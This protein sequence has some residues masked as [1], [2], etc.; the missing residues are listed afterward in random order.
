MRRHII[1]FDFKIFCSRAEKKLESIN[2]H[3]VCDCHHVS[4]VQPCYPAAARLL[5][6]L[7]LLSSAG[8]A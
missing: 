5:P 6:I 4:R 1:E 7:R 8:S 2:M 3:F